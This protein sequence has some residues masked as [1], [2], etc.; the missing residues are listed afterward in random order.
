V[1]HI[2]YTKEGS[3]ISF[4]KE[5]PSQSNPNNDCVLRLL[6]VD[7]DAHDAND[8]RDRSGG[9]CFGRAGKI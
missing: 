9:G 6:L 7:D 2:F 3:P 4:K 5:A 8:G 1:K